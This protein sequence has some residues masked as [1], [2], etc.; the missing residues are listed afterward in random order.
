MALIDRF[1]NIGVFFFLLVPLPPSLPS[2]GL[3][4]KAW[5]VVTSVDTLFNRID[6]EEEDID[7]HAHHTPDN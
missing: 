1:S 5:H 2:D 3:L 7:K 6:S 4:S